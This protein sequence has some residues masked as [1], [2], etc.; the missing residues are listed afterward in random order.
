MVL[1]WPRRPGAVVGAGEPRRRGQE[2]AEQAATP[3]Y[4][5]A[6]RGCAEGV[7]NRDARVNIFGISRYGL[8][9]PLV[10]R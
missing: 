9:K 7:Q 2:R 10:V 5:P 4:F 8:D 3:A 1:S 6:P